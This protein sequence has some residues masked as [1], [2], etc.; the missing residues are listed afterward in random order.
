[1][2]ALQSGTITRNSIGNIYTDTD[3]TVSQVKEKHWHFP[4]VILSLHQWH[5]GLLGD[6]MRWLINPK[7]TNVAVKGTAEGE[8][9]LNALS[10]WGKSLNFPDTDWEGGRTCQYFSSMNTFSID[11]S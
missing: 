1:M 10:D 2:T 11:L 6:M 5:S 7:V 3:S 4:N 8:R 9:W